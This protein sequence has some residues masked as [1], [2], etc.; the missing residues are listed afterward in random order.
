VIVMS[1]G[2]DDAKKAGGDEP[3]VRDLLA[4]GESPA[5]QDPALVSQLEAWFGLPSFQQ[6]DDEAA[7]AA[8]AAP[9]EASAVEKVQE[10]RREVLAQIDPALLA[11]V[12]RH[13]GVAEHLRVDDPP[14]RPWEGRVTAFDPTAIP[15][16]ITE[17]DWREVYIPNELRKDL[18]V[19][20]PQAFLRDLH[21]PEKEF[22]VRMQ[23][24]WDD[25]DPEQAQAE[26]DV[27]APVRETLRRDYRVGTTQPPAIRTM[28]EAWS[29]RLALM[30]RPWAES[31][32]ERAR[33]REVELNE[34]L[35]WG[36]SG[37]PGAVSEKP[38][39]TP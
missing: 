31:K 4:R 9:R 38:G 29:D 23:P 14:P 28:S 24:P 34:Q 19:S 5:V 7:A 39:G 27:M 1:A 10:R 3:R 22:Y 11:H 30:A 20:T 21:R 8:A 2:D 32:R 35:G 12:M 26:M 25:F 18:K 37:E 17:D 36:K 15:A 33:K 6:L 16:E 13:A